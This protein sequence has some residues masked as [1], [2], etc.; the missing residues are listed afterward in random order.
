MSI[1]AMYAASTAMKALDTKISVVA[2]NLA[3]IN[4]TA[5]KA[6]RTNFEDLFYQIRREP[7]VKDFNDNATPH[8]IQVGLGVNVSGTQLNFEKGGIDQTAR[9]LDLTIDG[10][11]F[12]QVRTFYNG[13][14]VTA[15][16]R[17]G[18]LVRNANGE[19]VLANSVGS[20]LE[21][22]ITIPEDASE[23][24]LAIGQDGVVSVVTQGGANRQ[25]I[26][27]IELARFV[28]PEG[29]KQIGKNLYIETDAS[30]QP[31]TGNPLQEGLGGLM[32]GALE[33]SNVNPVREL[34][35]LILTQRAFEM[36]SRS[37]ESAD[38]ALRVISNIRT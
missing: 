26:G 17:A 14:E 34:V 37:I 10:E 23:E 19:L 25:E 16:T 11:G 38:E 20:Y 6:S 22:G 28:N 31:V 15:Y 35:D 9:K 13:Q 12:F 36:N 8:G 2:N 18:N 3:N 5:F 27:Q 1:S 29:L 24:S 7:G 32:S 21:P 33:Q 4:T 30:G